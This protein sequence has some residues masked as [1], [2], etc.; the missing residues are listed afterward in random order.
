MMKNGLTISVIFE[1]QSANYGEGIGNISSLKQLTRGDGNTYTYISRQALRYSIINQLAWDNTPVKAEGGG[2]KKVVQFAPDASIKDYP[3]IDLFG[4]MKTTKG[5]NASTRNAVARLSHAIS[6]ESYKGD[7]DFLNNMGQSR[8][9]GEDNALA[10]SENHQSFYAYTLTI[11][12]D[13]VGKDEN[14]NIEISAAEKTKRVVSLLNTIKMLYRDIR[15]RRENLSPVFVIGGLYDIKN[16]FFEGK[17]KLK[18]NQLNI[19][20]LLQAISLEGEVKA[21]TEVGYLTGTFANEQAIKDKL[22]P[23]MIGEF[24]DSLTKKISF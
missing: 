4:Y 22:E 2:D 11:D 12:L 19:E 6:L 8:R 14:G 24:F 17:L 23:K 21:N 3:E 18:N 16:P 10:Q 20:T 13:R 5:N 15:G 9:I 1:A 7:T